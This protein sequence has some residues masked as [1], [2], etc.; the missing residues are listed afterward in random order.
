MAIPERPNILLLMADQFR[1]DCVGA[2]G[3]RAIRTP[4]LD[5]V[6]RTGISF[7]RAYSSTPSCTPARAGLLTGWAPWRHGMLGY[8]RVAERY[9]NEMP[10]MLREAGYYTMGIGKMHWHPQRNLHGFHRTL[11]DESGRIEAPGFVSDYRQWFRREAPGLDADATGIGWNDYAAKPYGLPE[12]LHPTRWTGDRAV[13]FLQGYREPSPWFLKVSFARPHSP[14][15]PPE[16]FWRMY[17]DAELP[18]AVVGRWAERYARRGDDL[19]PSTWWGDLGADQVRASRQGYYGAVTF[20]DEQIGRILAELDRRGEASRTLVV[21]T[22]DHGDMTGDHHLW[23]KTYPYEASARVPMLMRWPDRL[24]PVARGPRT[25]VELRDVLPTFMD[26]AGVVPRPYAFD[27]ISLL[28]LAAGRRGASPR[29]LDLEHSRCYW[30]ESDWTGITDGRHKYIHWSITGE[31]QL[32]DLQRDPNEL[33]DLAPEAASSALLRAWRGRMAGHLAARGDGWVETGAPRRRAKAMLYST[34]YP[35]RERSHSGR[36]RLRRW[37]SVRPPGP[38]PPTSAAGGRFISSVMAPMCP[39]R[40][41][42]P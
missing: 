7:P 28:D 23:R 12:H 1:A 42:R 35:G 24:R 21:F 20:I 5:A 8:G 9:G 4:N 37:S 22:S 31:E 40:P 26:A 29:Y 33:R 36:R 10:R 25:P 38:H 6:A 18:R 11:V 41:H 16:R 30:P 13:E 32:F 15:D 34:N 14:Y 39:R 27:G 17:E 2:N 3:N 19:R